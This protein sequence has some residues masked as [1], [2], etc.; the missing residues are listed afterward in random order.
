MKVKRNG[1]TG[2]LNWAAFFLPRINFQNKGGKT[3]CK[4]KT[5]KNFFI[6]RV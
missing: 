4:A 1:I 6:L 5:K 2:I 3:E